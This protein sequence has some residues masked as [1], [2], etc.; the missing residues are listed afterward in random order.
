[1]EDVDGG[2]RALGAFLREKI[3]RRCYKWWSLL[4]FAI[5]TPIRISMYPNKVA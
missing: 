4:M 2:V 5:Q 1:M 3:Y